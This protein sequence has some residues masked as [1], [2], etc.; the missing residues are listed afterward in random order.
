MLQFCSS[1]TSPHITVYQSIFRRLGVTLRSSCCQRCSYDNVNVHFTRLQSPL[2]RVAHGSHDSDVSKLFKLFSLPSSEVHHYSITSIIYFKV[3]KDQWSH[4]TLTD[5]IIPMMLEHENKVQSN[6]ISFLIS[7]CAVC[8]VTS[9]LTWFLSI[10][11][12]F[13]P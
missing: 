7:K 9:S 3:I 2:N 5:L 4:P 12:I 8:M 11:F 13:S 10:V 1:Q 6:A